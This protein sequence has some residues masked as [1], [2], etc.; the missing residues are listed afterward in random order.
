MTPLSDIFSISIT[1]VLHFDRLKAIYQSG[2]T[3]IPV[4]Q[5]RRDRIVGVVFAKDL[6]LVDPNDEIPVASILPFCSRALH[7]V[8]PHTNLEKLMQEMQSTRSHLFFVSDERQARRNVST[9][10]AAVG[11]VT[12]EDV[13]E[14]LI[15]DEIVDESDTVQDN[16]SRQKVQ[17]QRAP[18]RIEFFEMLQ[19]KELML[20][21]QALP[22]RRLAL[23]RG[24]SKANL[25]GT[26]AAVKSIDEMKALI[27][28]LSSNVGLFRPAA[29]STAA[30]RR[31][32]QRCSLVAIK[33]DEV[34]TGRYVY[35]R[36]V[37]T[38]QCCLLLHGRLQIRAGLEGFLS[39]VG[40]WTTLGLSALTDPHYRP[41]FTAR[42]LEPAR[43]LVITRS[44]L[45]AVQGKSAQRAERQSADA[46]LYSAHSEVEASPPGSPSTEDQ[47]VGSLEFESTR[48]R[49]VGWRSALANSDADSESDSW[50]LSPDRHRPG[51]LDPASGSP[52]RAQG[53]H[54]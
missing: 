45:Q 2:Y 20:I 35:V 8:P 52:H 5:D 25:L 21:S 38:S 43:I 6:V 51:E 31:L 16:I 3:R 17:E 36:G 4:Y 41:D 7:H 40:P 44:D 33:A 24:A 28:F 46:S 11:I 30:L 13:I 26:V 54:G 53:T 37:P 19:R 29:M 22:A 23:Q 1:D 47:S 48:S 12:M 49:P 18:L 14:E 9:V 39:E 34:S 27:S 42:M 50:R 10:A 32:V 15:S